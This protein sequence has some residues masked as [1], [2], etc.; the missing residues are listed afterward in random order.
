MDVDDAQQSAAWYRGLAITE[1]A[2]CLETAG[3]RWAALKGIDL[4][5]RVYERPGDRTMSDIDILVDGEALPR[6]ATALRHAGMPTRVPG[7]HDQLF[8][9]RALPGSPAIGIEV[10]FGLFP[11]PHDLAVRPT[12]LL[13]RRVWVDSPALD[14]RLPVLHP[15]EAWTHVAAHLAYTNIGGASPDRT[16]TDLRLLA[17]RT[18]IDPQRVVA[19]CQQWRVLDF[20]SS[21]LQVLAGPDPECPVMSAVLAHAPRS[22]RSALGRRLV[23][24]KVAQARADRIPAGSWSLVRA[25]LVSDPWRSARL[26]SFGARRRWA[27]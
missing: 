26:L 25:L 4:S 5:Y 6:A 23:R 14:F 8:L 21:V 17:Q 24:S 3:V 15:A 20:V 19:L 22:W 1:I 27:P 10:H 2:T 12:A 13:D 9:W 18:E 11:R 7:D 16:L